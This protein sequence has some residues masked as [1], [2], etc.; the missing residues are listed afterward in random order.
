MWRCPKSFLIRTRS[1]VYI[2]KNEVRTTCGSGVLNVLHQHEKH[3]RPAT[4]GRSDLNSENIM[5]PKRLIT[6]AFAF[7]LATTSAVR[8]QENSKAKADPPEP[9]AK[10]GKK[11]LTATDILK[12]RGVGSPRIS[13][14]GARV[15]YTAN[16]VKME[17]EK[18]WK[19]TTH[20]W[21][22]STAG[23]NATRAPS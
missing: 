23:G 20:V 6:I 15:A 2:G 10:D 12:I 14:D 1:R 4:A 21:V 7:L 13:P 17:K 22:V 8:G 9:R 18:E 16:E 19:Q 5:I 11:L 3:H